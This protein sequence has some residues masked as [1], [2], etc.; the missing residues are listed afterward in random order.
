VRSD[1]RRD[2]RL[3]SSCGRLDAVPQAG[4]SGPFSAVGS[5]NSVVSN[6]AVKQATVGLGPHCHLRR[7]GVVGRVDER[8]WAVSE[9]LTGVVYL[10]DATCGVAVGGTSAR[11]PYPSAATPQPSGSD[12]SVAAVIGPV[13]PDLRR[14]TTRSSQRRGFPWPTGERYNTIRR[15]T[16]TA[17]RASSAK[18]FRHALCIFDAL[19]Q[20]WSCDRGLVVDRFPWMP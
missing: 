14:T 13:R 6:R 18:P 17:I 15:P 3:P 20:V 8:L 10:P 1:V 4:E 19:A 5:S 2:G 9:E 16:R 12:C 7:P 11:Q